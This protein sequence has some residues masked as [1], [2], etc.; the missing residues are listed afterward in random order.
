MLRNIFFE[1]I[2]CP[3]ILGNAYDFTADSS[4]LEVP[5]DI[6]A[7]LDGKVTGLPMKE[8]HKW[9]SRAHQMLD[10]YEISK[11]NIFKILM[12]NLSLLPWA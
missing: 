12:R 10:L 3:P 7:S 11:E 9:K 8:V 4:E 1:T 6:C 5:R 2:A